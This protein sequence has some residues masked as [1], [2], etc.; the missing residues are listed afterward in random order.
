MLKIDLFL[1]ISFVVYHLKIPFLI[2]QTYFSHFWSTRSLFSSMQTEK[3]SRRNAKVCARMHKHTRKRKNTCH[4]RITSWV[5]TL[6]DL[7]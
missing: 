5:Q 3:R 6:R 1:L 4:R 7:L 2:L